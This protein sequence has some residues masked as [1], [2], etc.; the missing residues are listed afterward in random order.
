MTKISI[1]KSGWITDEARLKNITERIISCSGDI[2]LRKDQETILQNM[3]DFIV[4]RKCFSEKQ[5]DYLVNTE[6][7]LQ[8][9]NDQSYPSFDSTDLPF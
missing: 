1:I 8:R 9:A 6:E 4:T 7:W 5:Y 2:W 3:K